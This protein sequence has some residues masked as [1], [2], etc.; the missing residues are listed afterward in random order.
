MDPIVAKVVARYRV[1]HR[2]IMAGLADQFERKIRDLLGGPLD[3]QKGKALAAWM[4]SNFHFE[5]S[6]TPKGGKE[7]KEN[8]QKLY[9]VL[10]A[11]LG[12]SMD[13]EKLRPSI[14]SDWSKI[15]PKLNDL[16]RLFTEEGGKIVPKEVKVGANT[17]RNLSGFSEKQLDG[18][19]KALEA[20]FDELKG[21][22]K[23]ALAGGLEVALAGPGEFRG[24]SSGK[25]KSSEDV[26]YV[27]ATPKILKRSR[28]T[29][30]AFD[31]I[32]VHELGHR[33]EYKRRP[34]ID[35]ERQEWFTSPYSQKEGEAFAEL[36][37]ISNFEIKGPW[38]QETVDRF[39]D[40]MTTGKVTEHEPV[41]LP[42][43]LKALVGR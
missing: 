21:W 19:I 39:E 15:Q 8:L 27:R 32:I 9:W 5:G 3:T 11:G 18:Y 12:Q 14:E 43:H 4:S 6:K 31:Y 34:S 20:V 17:Y 26:L 37:A 29:Y 40:F 23:K 24:T 36:F 13:V 25:Y 28:G 16:V 22:R 30:A 42:P 10:N 2:F 41:E 33:Y 7:L 1:A 35:F 38:K